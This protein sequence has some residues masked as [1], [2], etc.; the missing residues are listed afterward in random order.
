MKAGPDIAK[1]ASLIGDPARANMLSA[2]MAG[3]ALTATELALEAG[4]TVQ[5][6]S[7]HLSKLEQG[8]LIRPRKQGRHRYFALSGADVAQVLETLM[9]VS[10]RLGGGRVRPGPKEPEL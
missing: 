5:T 6:A 3:G 7:A 9:G 2:L 4:V 10:A 8:G 1:L